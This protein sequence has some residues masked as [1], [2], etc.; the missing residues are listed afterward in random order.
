MTLLEK[1]IFPSQSNENPFAEGKTAS[2]DQISN[3]HRGFHGLSSTFIDS[4]KTFHQRPDIEQEDGSESTCVVCCEPIGPNHSNY[5]GRFC[6]YCGPK[7]PMVRAAA[8]AHPKGFTVSEIW[9]DLA[10]RGNR[11][12]RKEHLPAMLGYLGY[13]EYAYTWK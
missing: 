10:S 13:I 2:C 12:P 7:I 4:S 9:E 8:K 11:P 5:Y 3:F 1:N 6:S